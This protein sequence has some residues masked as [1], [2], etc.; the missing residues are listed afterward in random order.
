MPGI[1]R[2]AWGCIGR[3][4]RHRAGGGVGTGDVHGGVVVPPA[5][6]GVPY[7]V[8]ESAGSVAQR[9]GVA[10]AHRVIPSRIV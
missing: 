10:L 2:V 4:Q 9:A 3:S 8:R 1:G 6:E 5:S 7:R